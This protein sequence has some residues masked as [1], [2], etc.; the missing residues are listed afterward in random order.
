LRALARAPL[1]WARVDVGLVDERWLRPDDHDSNAWL[2]HTHLLHDRAA[3][4]HFDPLT[5]PGRGIEEA[6]AT[7]NLH[8]RHAADVVVLGMGG[9][10]HTASLFPGMADL[11]RALASPEPYVA[12][13]ATGC[14][15]AGPW[16][17]RITS[18]PTGLAPAGTRILLLR[19]ADKRAVFER[20]LDGDDPRELPIRIAFLV[21]GAPLDVYWCG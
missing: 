16:S 2:V 6:V 20:A 19:G 12:V 5:R 9:D 14:P 7:A 13:N 18:T 10:G 15:G 11:E 4:A 3:A 1:E 8:A 17:L 21:P